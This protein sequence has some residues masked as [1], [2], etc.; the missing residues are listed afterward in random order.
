[1]V[2]LVN[3]KERVA[4]IL[5]LLLLFSVVFNLLFF[6]NLIKIVYEIT[7]YNS[8]R[9]PEFAVKVA[10]GYIYGAVA[11]VVTVASGL[12][13]LFL[14]KYTFCIIICT[15]VLIVEQIILLNSHTNFSY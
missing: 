5:L 8:P 6:L 4:K 1:M 14:R 11:S 3:I 7:P 2:Q 9:P 12:L 10:S 15:V 13:S